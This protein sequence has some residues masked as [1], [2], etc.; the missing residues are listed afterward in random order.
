MSA[1]SASKVV[2]LTV[3]RIYASHTAFH[4]AMQPCPVFTLINEHSAV[5]SGRAISYRTSTLSFKDAFYQVHFLVRLSAWVPRR[6]SKATSSERL[7]RIPLRA[8]PKR[9]SA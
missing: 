5:L 4:I 1:R 2:L 6:F 9:P 8:Q 7:G 3:N